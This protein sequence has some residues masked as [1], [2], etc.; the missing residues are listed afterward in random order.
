MKK[1]SNI[2]TE[3]KKRVVYKKTVQCKRNFFREEKKKYFGS[4]VNSLLDVYDFCHTIY[5]RTDKNIWVTHSKM[6]LRI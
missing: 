4:H 5:K 2:E 3:V 1:L 6:V